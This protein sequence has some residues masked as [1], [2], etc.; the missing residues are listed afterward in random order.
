[1]IVLPTVTLAA[2]ADALAIAEMSRD[3]I[4]QGLGWSW[5]RMRVLGAIHDKS[6][7]V[8]VIQEQK[9]LLGFGIMG[10][11]EVKAHL[12]LFSV[13]ADRRQ[14][15]LGAHLLAWLEKSAVV[16]GVERIQLEARADNQAAIAFYVA[17]GYRETGTVTGYYARKLDAV[18]LE[19]LLRV[20][21]AAIDPGSSPG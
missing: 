10:Y 14:R 9:E 5:T 19:K 16:A 21:P 8:A 17:Q 13:R 2:P 6:T 3:T 4:E 11:G 20:V 15:G 1:M 18:R 7:N 12:S